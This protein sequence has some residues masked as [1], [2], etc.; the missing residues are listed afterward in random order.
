MARVHHPNIVTFIGAVFDDNPVPMIITELMDM[1]LRFAY[2]KIAFTKD[3]MMD[4]FQDI[5]YALHYPIIHRD[6]IAPNVLLNSL[7]QAQGQYVA[8]VTDFG[9]AN[10]EKL[11]KTSGEGAIIYSAPEM[12]PPTDRRVSRHVKQTVKVDSFSYGAYHCAK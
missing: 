10:L 4:I 11:S 5:A 8:K 12:F 1:N 3:Q 2:K 9:S 6:L 7:P